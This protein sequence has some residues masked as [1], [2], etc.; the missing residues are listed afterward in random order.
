MPSLGSNVKVGGCEA[1]RGQGVRAFVL[2]GSKVSV[3]EFARHGSALREGD[4]TEDVL[5]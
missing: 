4:L 3:R 5:F 1:A 2:A